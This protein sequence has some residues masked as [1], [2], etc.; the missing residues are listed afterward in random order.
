MKI[1][2][3]ASGS[4]NLSAA[5]AGQLYGPALRTSVS[6]LEQFAACS[7]RFFVHSGL[8]AEERVRFELDSRRKGSF[9]HLAL[10]L[11]HEQLQKDGQ[12]WHDLNAAEARRRIA[13][14]C[15]ALIPQFDEGL[16]AANPLSRFAAK[17]MAR[18]LEDFVAAMAEWMCQYDFEPAAVELEFGGDPQTGSLPAWE[19]DLGSGH[20]LRFRGRIDRV[21]MFASGPEA[22]VV[23]VDYKSSQHKLDPV[24][25]QHGVQLQLPAYLGVLRRL[26]SPGKFFDQDRLIPAGVF[27]INLRGKFEYGE[28]RNEVLQSEVP[29]WQAAYKHAGR[30]DLAAL[31]HLDNRGVATGTQF[32]YRI[33]ANGQ[34]AAN[35]PDAMDHAAF[36]QMLDQVEENLIR[37]GRAIFAGEIALNP[38]QKGTLRA[39]DRCE[40][41]GICRIDPWDHAFRILTKSRED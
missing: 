36:Q 21:D 22:L 7:F 9:Q 15:A 5:L 41:Q 40:Y 13:E 10:S 14:I 18:S 24:L 27:Y 12:T 34:P 32:N 38:Y 26:A 33:K 4:A 2:A 37:M 16:L 19:L 39:C 35:N 11:F 17:S 6:R 30:F 3:A 31:P 25:L 29:A 23:V 20:R 8:Q 1:G 28:N